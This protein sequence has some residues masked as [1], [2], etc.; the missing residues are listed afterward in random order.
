[1]ITESESIFAA[2]SA[3]SHGH[4]NSKEKA[5]LRYSR[6]IR[7]IV[8]AVSGRGDSRTSEGHPKA[9]T[10]PVYKKPIE[11]GVLAFSGKVV[12][13]EKIMAAQ[14]DYS[15]SILFISTPSHGRG[16]PAASSRSEGKAAAR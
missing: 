12:L 6:Q 16:V 5:S 11:Q 10:N 3:S 2:V 14:M 15:K 9:A 7:H 4:E 1:M 13:L 8:T